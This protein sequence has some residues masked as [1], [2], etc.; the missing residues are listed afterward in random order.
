MTPEEDGV[1]TRKCAI[2][3]LEQT[4]T[5]N[6]KRLL[7]APIAKIV[8]FLYDKYQ[9]EISEF[10]DKEDL[11]EIFPDNNKY[12]YYDDINNIDCY[13]I[14]I[15]T[16]LLSIKYDVVGGYIVDENNFYHHSL[17]E[18]IKYI[19]AEKANRKNNKNLPKRAQIIKRSIRSFADTGVAICEATNAEYTYF[20]DNIIEEYFE[21]YITWGDFLES[22]L[23]QAICHSNVANLFR[24]VFEK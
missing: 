15:I 8:S 3:G 1:R 23:N 22:P 7:K 20:F 14:D 19:I 4:A 24:E 5:I 17:V 2:C 11:Y 21:K 10:I 13:I 16:I 12:D 6:K 18:Y 9:T